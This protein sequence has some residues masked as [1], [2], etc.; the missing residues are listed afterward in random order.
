MTEYEASGSTGKAACSE[1]PGEG[2]RQER[3]RVGGLLLVG[4][5]T[6]FHLL[7]N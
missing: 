1:K 3:L 2:E 4:S 6:F 5:T 7:F